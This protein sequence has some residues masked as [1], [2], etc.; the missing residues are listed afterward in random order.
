WIA[1]RK[2]LLYVMYY[3][4]ALI[5]WLRFK[6]EETGSVKYYFLTLLF[7]LFSLLS[8]GQAVTFPA[9]L[10]LIDY[11]LRRRLTKEI[12]LEKIPF[13]ILAVAFGIVAIYAQH[14]THAIN[15]APYFSFP[16]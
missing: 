5:T 6:K 4:L 13:F 2:D 15:V 7:F 11:F 12:L 8:K 16:D 3:L 1:E 14:S 10:L 9:V